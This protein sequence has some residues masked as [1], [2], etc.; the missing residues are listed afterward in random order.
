VS[1]LIAREGDLPI[2]P[3][4]RVTLHFS[5]HLASG[6]EVDTTRRGKPAQ[7]QYIGERQDRARIDAAAAHE[8]V[9]GASC[10]KPL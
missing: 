6:E 4:T 9:P 7:H 1:T 3:G 2:G 10:R 8:H 5:I